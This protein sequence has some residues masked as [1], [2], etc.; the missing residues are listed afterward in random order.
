MSKVQDAL[1][2]TMTPDELIEQLTFYL[3]TMPKN[4]FPSM[5][6]MVWGQPGVGKSQIVRQIGENTNRPVIDIRL[7]LK[8]PTDLS[9]IPYFDTVNQKMDYGAPSELPPTEA[10]LRSFRD[11]IGKVVVEPSKRSL[12]RTEYNSLTT[13]VKAE[14]ALS[15][16]EKSQLMTLVL[17]GEAIILLDELSSAPPAVQAAA[18]QLVLDRRVGTY[19]LPKGVSIVAAGN[20][21]E[22]NSV[23]YSMPT[24]LRNR[25][26]HF[27]IVCDYKSWEKWAINRGKIH[28]SVVGFLKAHKQNL[29]RFNPKNKMEYAFATPRAWEFVSNVLWSLSDENGRVNGK[30]K[31]LLSNSVGSL[32]GNAVAAEFMTVFELVGK[33]PNATDILEGK[34]KKF[35]FEDVSSSACYSLIIN[36]CHTMREAQQRF[37]LDKEMD[38]VEAQVKLNTYG[39]N[40]FRFLMDN[41]EFQEDF[42]I[43]GA[44]VAL[45]QY[46]L[47]LLECDGVD[48]LLDKYANILSEV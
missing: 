40:F 2:P 20:R 43:L 6:T 45:N 41:L 38:D 47:P 15:D 17:Q 27:T 12:T 22:D 36:L 8:D 19:E 26:A 14:E 23:I 42:V 35:D 39:N 28:S 16:E 24:P 18:L 48:E 30:M 31:K 1:H 5:P 37:D 9:G 4:G 3:E 29:N 7:L 34:I 13:K 46:D 10:E 11:A 44:S 25:F 21:S 33:L 32:V